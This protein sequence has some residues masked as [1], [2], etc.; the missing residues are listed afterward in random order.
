MT[1]WVEMLAR[2]MSKKYEQKNMIKRCDQKRW[3]ESVI[4]HMS[5]T[6]IKTS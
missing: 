1:I 6:V 4:Y 2:Y 5:I 3:Y